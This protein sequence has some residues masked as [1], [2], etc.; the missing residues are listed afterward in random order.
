MWPTRRPRRSRLGL[1]NAASGRTKPAWPS[2]QPVR[3]CGSRGRKKRSFSSAL[4]SR[5]AKPSCASSSKTKARCPTGS[6][7][8]AAARRR[9]AWASCPRAVARAPRGP[10]A[11]VEDYAAPFFHSFSCPPP[12]SILVSPIPHRHSFTPL[13]PFT[14]SL[15]H[16]PLH[17]FSFPIYTDADASSASAREALMCPFVSCMIMVTSRTPIHTIVEK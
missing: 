13:S 3:G 9:G 11:A 16:P 5:R 15:V 10:P 1:L 8:T 12:L 2:W 14:P 6:T 4:T 7:A 17:S